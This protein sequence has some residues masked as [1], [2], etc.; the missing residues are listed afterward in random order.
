MQHE[1][2][3]RSICKSIMDM[4]ATK[5]MT[6][7]RKIFNIYKVIFLCNMHLV[8]HIMDEAIGIGSIVVEVEMVGKN[9]RVW[10]HGYPSRAQVA[11]QLALSEQVLSNELKV[12]L[13]VNCEPKFCTH[14]CS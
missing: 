6:L 4:R 11:S 5:H 13:L 14:T 8:G 3:S 9:N 12:Q 1:T 2:H 10:H 7:H